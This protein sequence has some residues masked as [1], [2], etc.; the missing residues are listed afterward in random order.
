[1]RADQRAKS[2]KE[3]L[4]LLLEIDNFISLDFTIWKISKAFSYMTRDK[5]RG[6]RVGSWKAISQPSLEGSGRLQEGYICPKWAS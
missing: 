4:E 5:K 1:M 6:L 3:S 2:I